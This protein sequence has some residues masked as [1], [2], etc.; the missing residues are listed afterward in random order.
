MRKIILNIAISLDGYIEGPEGEY[1]WCFNDQDY[2]MMEFL[3]NVDAV[4]FGRSAYE[5]ILEIGPDY[6]SDK[7]RYVFSNSLKKAEKGWILVNGDLKSKMRYITTGTGSNI[8]LFG[9]GGLVRSFLRD[10]LLDRM[11]LAVHPILLGGGKPLFG[12]LPERTSLDLVDTET[13][14]SGLVQLTY[15]VKRH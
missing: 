9:G 13:Y 8:W 2:G 3:L 4:F 14:R 7:K 15:D 12:E 11:M 5:R 6:F 1:D 10:G